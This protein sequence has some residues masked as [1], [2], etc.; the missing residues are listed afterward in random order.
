M[1]DVRSDL[2]ARQRQVLAALER[3]TERDGFPPSLRELASEVGLASPSSV[4][5]HVR[6]LEGAE[7]V[8]RRPGCPRAIRTGVP[9]G[10]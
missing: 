8:A 10:A 9:S 4:L 5:R 2:T 1:T 7:L 6:V 3:L